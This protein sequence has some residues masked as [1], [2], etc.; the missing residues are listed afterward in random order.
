VERGQFEPVAATEPPPLGALMEEHE[1]KRR[2]A[3]PVPLVLVG[4][5]AT[6]ALGGGAY[7]WKRRRDKRPEAAERKRTVSALRDSAV[8]IEK[9]SPA[10]GRDGCA[11]RCRKAGMSAAALG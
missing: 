6:V 3:S 2:R 5:T 7:A 4:A 10:S 1:I 11:R 8:D 9:A